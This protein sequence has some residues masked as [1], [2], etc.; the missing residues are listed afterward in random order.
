MVIYKGETLLGIAA[1]FAGPVI[2]SSL[3]HLHRMISFQRKLLKKRERLG[4]HSSDD[5]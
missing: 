4:E 1:F 2:E 5:A 3:Y